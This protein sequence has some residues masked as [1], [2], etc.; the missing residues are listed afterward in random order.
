MSGHVPDLFGAALSVRGGGPHHESGT[1]LVSLSDITEIE[2][3]I[4][5]R[6]RERTMG[7]HRSHTH[8]AGFDFVGLRDWQAGDRPSSIDW[9]QSTLSNFTRLVVREFEQPSTASVIVVA[10][11]S[12][13]TRC[14]VGGQSIAAAVARAIAIIGMS[15]VFFQDMFGLI[16]FD[17]RLDRLSAVQP[18]IGRNQVMLCLDAYERQ[19]NLQELRHTDNLSTTIASFMRRTALVP[20][21]S[22]F[23]MPNPEAV[24]REL[25]QLST[26]HD[27]V[28][29]LIDAAFAFE[30]PATS[31][32]W[33][34]AFDV[35]TG[36]S[37]VLSRAALARMADR[38]REWQTSI[39]RTARDL[40]LDLVRIGI[41]PVQTD[42]ALA[43]FVAERR[44]RKVS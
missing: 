1:S 22:D 23:L 35:E 12:R 20:F 33:I 2:L 34:D 21:V 15:A 24:L 14:G 43:E 39:E 19:R 42:L 31:A 6:M 9:P 4:L 5:R 3:T 44:L 11:G 32:G 8:G 18:R 13:S 29:L 10:D 28:V 25:S 37:R 40:D 17:E 38:V 26:S 27:V 7:D 36:R 41:D 16:T 30:L